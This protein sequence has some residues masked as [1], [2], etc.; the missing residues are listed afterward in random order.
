[1]AGTYQW[2]TFGAAKLQL[3]QRLAIDITNDT[4]FW[5]NA[6][7]G[8]RIQQALRQFNVLTQTWK[9]EFVFNNT[10]PA[11]WNSLATLAGSPRLRTITDTYC[12]VDMEYHLLEPGTGGVWS[13]TNQF[14]ISD[15]SQALQRRRDEMLV[16]SACN[17]VL[18]TGIPSTPGVSRVL[19]PD[20]TLDVPR[21]RFIPVGST[22]NA[23]V[24]L[25]RDDAGA[26]E[27][28]EAPI[29]EVLQQTTQPYS[30]SSE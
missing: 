26:L 11:V 9:T 22:N 6:E 13:G 7:L 28:Y 17:D 21:L 23:G 14:T 25:Y 2:L 12:Y 16:I 18:S 3:A 1:M 5:Q 15:L 10:G 19:M 30:L 29:Y 27:F 20:S 24:T 8:V 4:A